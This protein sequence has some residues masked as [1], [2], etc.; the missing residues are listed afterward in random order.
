[1]ET[2]EDEQSLLVWECRELSIARADTHEHEFTETTQKSSA[3]IL[4]VLSVLDSTGSYN[5]MHAICDQTFRPRFKGSLQDA[6]ILLHAPI[7]IHWE[8]HTPDTMEHIFL[9]LREILHTSYRDQAENKSIVEAANVLINCFC[10]IMPNASKELQIAAM[11]A[12]ILVKSKSGISWFDNLTI[13]LK[14][15]S[16]HPEIQ[17]LVEEYNA[18]WI[19]VFRSLRN[20]RVTD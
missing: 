20:S 11:E 5:H 17:W 10:N 3:D 12:N 13:Q 14:N 6:L 16:R 19:K 15:K 2:R 8:R 18:T 9:L 4:Q 1:M 7:T